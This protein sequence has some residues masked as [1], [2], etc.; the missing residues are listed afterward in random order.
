MMIDDIAIKE[1]FE[2]IAEKALRASSRDYEAGYESQFEKDIQKMISDYP[3][4]RAF[5]ISL[6]DRFLED[7]PDNEAT[8]HTLWHIESFGD[9]ST[10]KQI[11]NMIRKYCLNGS[12]MQ[13]SGAIENLYELFT[14][15][16]AMSI[17]QQMLANE[18]DDKN[19]WFH[20]YILQ[21][22]KDF[23]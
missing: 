11:K 4:H 19:N 14:N 8:E 7:H 17:L 21:H 5:I 13:K 2:K 10:F 6:L 12:Y 23:K 18:P 9:L 1:E 16:E 3:A 22:M 20:D 15:E